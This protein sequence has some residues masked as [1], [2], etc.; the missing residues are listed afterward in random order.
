MQQID[1]TVEVHYGGWTFTQAMLNLLETALEDKE[2][3]FF[4]F[5]SDSCIPLIPFPQWKRTLQHSGKSVINSCPMSIADGSERDTRWNP[6]MDGLFKR[7]HWR[8]SSSWSALTRKH[9]E[10]VTKPYDFTE[11]F[12][13]ARI[14]DEHYIP[15][16]IA[17]HGLDN[18][19]TCND[20]YMYVYRESLAA[21]HPSFHT[22]DM[23]NAE[24]F[25]KKFKGTH[26]L[27]TSAGESRTFGSKCTGLSDPGP[28][29][30]RDTPV[31]HFAARKFSPHS[32][33]GVLHNLKYLLS[34]PDYPYDR[35][36]WIGRRGNLRYMEDPLV[37]DK[38]SKP[39]RRYYYV[40]LGRR[41]E[42]IRPQTAKD[43]LMVD[44]SYATPV[45]PEEEK[46]PFSFDV[47]D[48]IAGDWVNV[49][50]RGTSGL[51]R[52]IYYI[53]KGQRHACPDFETF[54]G[55]YCRNVLCAVCSV[56]CA[57]CCVLGA[58]CCVICDA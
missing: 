36:P 49:N 48:L 12:K 31:C 2:N 5:L 8:K 11:A 6:K 14:S 51:S 25:E 16:V 57:V 4:C 10:L 40:E 28:D 1:N 39:T 41:R 3:Q 22:S 38:E 44:P 17:Y 52:T 56:L 18:E 54:I 30:N 9:A 13:H 46:M 29:G 26:T 33:D 58:V 19:T 47:P 37:L 21:A 53:A 27:V 45:S 43:L 32:R 23:I 55:V 15:S 35:D 34:E 20:G 24:L 7:D 50:F 42:I